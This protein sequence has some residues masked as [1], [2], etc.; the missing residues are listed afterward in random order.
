M[1]IWGPVIAVVLA[2]VVATGVA[3][4]AWKLTSDRFHKSFDNNAEGD[5]PPG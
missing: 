4:I 5:D 2:L 1:S 3:V